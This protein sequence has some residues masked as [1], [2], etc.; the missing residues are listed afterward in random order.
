M[1]KANHTYMGC[2]VCDFYSGYKLSKAFQA[3]K[4]MGDFSDNGHSMLIIANH[5]SWWDG[6]IQYR[7]NR[8]R[9]KRK[10][11]VMMLE[12]Q[13]LRYKILNRGGAFSIRKQSRD[14]I[15]SLNYC[16]D[17]LSDSRNLVLMFPQGKIESIYTS[18]FR[19]G[20]G[21]DYL[22]KRISSN[23]QL[24]FNINLVDYFSDRKPSLSI[25][26]QPFDLSPGIGYQDVEKAFN[27]FFYSC[28]QK[29]IP[30]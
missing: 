15:E 9:Y 6:F 12:E 13:L 10:F 8:H 16:A 24:I 23:T 5:F 18:E 26:T 3:V 22:L 25:Y 2:K 17:L 30:E 7:L 28:K 21:L 1:I 20:S 4:Y 19:F 29:Q 27:D 14:I 11:H